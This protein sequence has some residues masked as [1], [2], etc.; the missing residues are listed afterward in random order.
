MCATHFGH[1]NY[2][3]HTRYTNIF[4][5]VPWPLS[6]T[7]THNFSTIRSNFKFDYHNL[8]AYTLSSNNLWM[9]MH[10]SCNDNFVSIFRN[11][12]NS[13]QYLRMTEKNQF[14]HEW[15]YRCSPFE[16]LHFSNAAVTIAANYNDHEQEKKK[17]KEQMDNPIVQ[18]LRHFGQEN[19]PTS[20]TIAHTTTTTKKR[21]NWMKFK[22]ERGRERFYSKLEIN[23]NAKNWFHLTLY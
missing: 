20:I 16:P 7:H 14:A 19:V 12:T 21:V 1:S 18:M 4:Q 22:W 15:N 5:S 13:S 10:F 6:H 23:F 3:Q 8:F 9:R 2:V 11:L 17:K